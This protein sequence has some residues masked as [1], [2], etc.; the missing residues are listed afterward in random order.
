[1][2]T[3]TRA[4]VAIHFRA[5]VIVSFFILLFLGWLSRLNRPIVYTS[6]AAAQRDGL[7][8]SWGLAL[9]QAVS[10]GSAVSVAL[11]CRNTRPPVLLWKLPSS[12]MVGVMK[13]SRFCLLRDLL[14]L[15]KAK[16]ANGMSP[17]IGTLV[18]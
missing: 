7:V 15:R 6:L 12:T 9:S 17:R 16:P 13:M 5:A 8:Q 11:L 3:R 1:M 4:A 10:L 2:P 18:H 14:S